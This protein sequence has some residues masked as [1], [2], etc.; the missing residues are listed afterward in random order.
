MKY[1]ITENRLNNLVSKYLEQ[2]DWWEWDI[3]DGEFN[4]A[5]GKFETSKILFR[6]QYSSIVA[7]HSFDVIYISD[8]LVTKLTSLFSIASSEAIRIIIEWFNKRYNKSLTMENFEW[9]DDENQHQDD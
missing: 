2:L 9:M 3:G 8:Y 7:G 4:L 6:I 5:D 1:I